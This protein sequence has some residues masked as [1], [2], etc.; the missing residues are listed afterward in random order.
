MAPTRAYRDWLGR[1][2]GE[3]AL[4]ELATKTADG[5]DIQPLY[6]PQDR[7]GC[8]RGAAPAIADALL[9]QPPA[10]RFRRL[11]EWR[12]D[13]QTQGLIAEDLRFGVRN[14]ALR[15]PAAEAA[16]SVEGIAA[17]FDGIADAA[18]HIEGTG[19]AAIL[20]LALWRRLGAPPDAC[21]GLDPWRL[22]L[23]P[24]GPQGDAASALNACAEI[25]ARVQGEFAEA[26][27][28]VI[29]GTLWHEAASPPAQELGLMLAAA[30]ACLRALET[31][32]FDAAAAA[33]QLELRVAVDQDLYLSLA[34]IRAL[35]LLWDQVL[36][37]CGV[38]EGRRRA[39]IAAHSSAAMAARRDPW[40]NGLRSTI[41]ALAAG[42]GGCDLLAIATPTN[43]GAAAAIAAMRQARALQLLLTQESHINEVVDPMAGSWFGE[44]LTENLAQ[45]AWQEFN[46]IEERGGMAAAVADGWVHARIESAATALMSDIEC[47]RQPI[48][49]V[50]L[51]PPAEA[52]EGE[53]ASDSE[54][55]ERAREQT[56]A[57]PETADGEIDTWLDSAI[58]DWQGSP[59]GAGADLSASASPPLRAL[60]R[61]LPFERLWLAANRQR[62]RGQGPR[63]LLVR[64]GPASGSVQPA[65]AAGDLLATAGIEAVC[66]SSSAA[67]AKLGTEQLKV[68]VLCGT[69][70]DYA[71]ADQVATEL[72]AAGASLIA[73][74]E[75]PTDFAAEGPVFRRGGN[76]V[77]FLELLLQ[78]L[79]P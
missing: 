2:G 28:L 64:L 45:R 8:G 67:A 54:T 3:A 22:A 37:A 21:L 68:A 36:A 43:L 4:A 53:A 58:A 41:A 27:T 47:L 61:S 72:K 73:A 17:P 70:D 56:R 60:R 19:L 74:I 30:V 25:G 5:I 77:S 76:A 69:A 49:G 16:P 79:L 31:Q 40:N 32:G 13:D 10:G 44:S 48:I 29:D 57:E 42:A 12:G 52:D 9:D 11:L 78:P 46:A 20:T 34:K 24:D 39:Q 59:A 18:I 7:T 50:S 35:R 1:A 75:P 66:A 65:R 33:K 55:R 23:D 6:G 62:T 71:E 51:Y 38:P 63:A 14:F 26:R 15:L